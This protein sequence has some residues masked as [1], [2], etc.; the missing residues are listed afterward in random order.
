MKINTPDFWNAKDDVIPCNLVKEHGE[1]YNTICSWI[2]KSAHSNIIDLGSGI[3]PIPFLL[4]KRG[5]IF[6]DR[7]YLCVDFSSVALGIA[8]EFCVNIKTKQCD[9]ES[10]DASSFSKKFDIVICFNVLEYINDYADMVKKMVQICSGKMIIGIQVGKKH[11]PAKKLDIIEFK[12]IIGEL[13][14]KIEKDTAI[15]KW[16]LSMV[17]MIS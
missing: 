8:K 17:S 12:K 14:L 10:I 11:S 3:G 13:N 7:E 4:K 2:F 9:I 15:D 1:I 6:K 5:F 16:Y